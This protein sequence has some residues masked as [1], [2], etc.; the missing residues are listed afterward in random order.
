MIGGI[1]E[2]LR[3]TNGLG[4]VPGV[5][6]PRIGRRSGLEQTSLLLSPL[7]DVPAAQEP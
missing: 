5:V 2:R 7:F 3:A 4:F 6:C 1:R